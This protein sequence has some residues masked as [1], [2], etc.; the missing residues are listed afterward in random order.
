MSQRI[1]YRELTDNGTGYLAVQAGLALLVLLGAGVALWM[2][3]VGHYVTGMDNQ[4]VW[5]TPHVFAVLLILA[6]SGALNVA[7]LASVFGRSEYKPLSRLSGV[8]AMALL[9]GGLAVLVLDL[10][11]PDRLIVAMTHYNLQSIFAWNI[12]LYTGFFVVVAVYLW[13]QMERRMNR[14]ANAAGTVAFAWRI[15]LTTGTGS[16]F[17]FLVARSA[18]DTALLAPLFIAA[19]LS[20]GTA[21]FILVASGLLRV[22]N[23]RLPQ[24]L[25]RGLGRLQVLFI[26]ATVYLLAIY[27][28]THAYM[29]DRHGVLRFLLLEGGVYPALFWGVQILLGAV[30]PLFLLL[31]GPGAGA[32]MR[33]VA[34]AGLVLLGGLAHLYVTI[35]G[36]QAYPL[37]LFPGMTVSSTFFDGQVT[38]YA[39]TLPEVVLGIGGIALATLLV[40]LA[41]RVL[42][43]VPDALPGEAEER[44]EAEAATREPDSEAA[45]QTAITQQDTA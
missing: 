15:V 32:P 19:S 39:P 31:T 2:M 38:H 36:A 6:A 34:A 13:F 5:G 20:Y 45:P 44:R 12:F 37:A 14:H 28:V 43:I 27:L 10:G 35:I 18:F 8:L 33:L 9:A 16:I 11:R 25:L 3:N 42:P 22:Q 7:S 23:R 41:T 24:E 30:L 29:P 4:V 1:Q 21:A 17:G 40:C 26:L